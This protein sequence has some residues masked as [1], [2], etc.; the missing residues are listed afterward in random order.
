MLAKAEELK[1]DGIRLYQ[2]GKL[3]EAADAFRDAMGKNP[4]LSQLLSYTSTI[5]SKLGKHAAA[6]KDAEDC[7]REH[8]RYP[9]GQSDK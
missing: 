4:K 5:Q 7:I 8:P 3:L 9:G 6:L 1:T 2:E